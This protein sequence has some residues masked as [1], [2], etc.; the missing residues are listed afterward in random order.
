METL[1]KDIRYGLRG[2]LQHRAFTAVVVLTL[3]VG[4]GANT[5]IFSTVDALLLRP[6]S[7]PNQQRL[8]VLWEQNLAVGSERGA[9]APGNF[10]DWREQNQVC[11][12]LVA[13]EQKYFEIAG[14]ANPERF[15]GYG[16]T[17]GFFEALGVKAI[18]GR[19]FLP[20]ESEPGH[21]QVVVLKYSFWQQH[22]GGDPDIVGKTVTL[23]RRVFTVVG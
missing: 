16:V 11:D 23:N 5:T 8:I 7:L 10:T 1:F 4:I 3:A 15:A 2:L 21:E 22:F 18:R 19:T 9:V 17:N 20:E 6:F 14:G 13:V 12:Q